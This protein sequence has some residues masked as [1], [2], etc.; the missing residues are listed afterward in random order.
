VWPS[1][2]TSRVKYPSR[3]N[4]GISFPTLPHRMS[5]ND[6]IDQGPIVEAMR[7]VLAKKFGIMRSTFD[8]DEPIE[9]L[10]LDSMAFVE[11]VF[12]L[13]TALNVHFPDV[14]RELKTLGD[15][16]RF[17]TAEVSRQR[18]EAGHADAQ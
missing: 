9:A 2:S 15:F 10:G 3:M 13:E 6:L 8:A 17:V 4:V 12:D 1:D 11:Y 18:T 7:E 14:P 5:E 16:V